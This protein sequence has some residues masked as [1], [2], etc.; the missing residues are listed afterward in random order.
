LAGET[1]DSL[2]AGWYCDRSLRIDKSPS[3]A[4]IRRQQHM[5][6]LSME[7]Q[8]RGQTGSGSEL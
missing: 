7:G 6:F 5:C 3:S 2:V 1:E 8:L 4:V